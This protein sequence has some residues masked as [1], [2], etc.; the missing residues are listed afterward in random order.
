[1]AD[2]NFES[3]FGA[4]AGGGNSAGAPRL[5]AAAKGTY[6]TQLSS[7]SDGGNGGR[8]PMFTVGQLGNSYFKVPDDTRIGQNSPIAYFELGV[9][10]FSI[11]GT[12]VETALSITFNNWAGLFWYDNVDDL[13]YFMVMEDAP[14]QVHLCTVTRGGTLALVGTETEANLSAVFGVQTDNQWWE[15][16]AQGSGDFTIYFGTSSGEVASI[17]SSTGLVTSAGAPLILTDATSKV[18]QSESNNIGYITEDGKIAI[19]SSVIIDGQDNM[20]LSV[21]RKN[22]NG[23]VMISNNAFGF[24][25]DDALSLTVNLRFDKWDGKVALYRNTTT[26]ASSMDIF[27]QRCWD[28]TEFDQWLHDLCDWLGVDGEQ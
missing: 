17:S 21:S 2:A 3:F 8:I 28:I 7:V 18:A 1:M 20:V 5:P 19:G 15:R 12:A 11:I 10:Q 25:V 9:Q 14:A 26:S 4:G 13:F 16:A 27:G 22:G 6:W 23:A 24:V